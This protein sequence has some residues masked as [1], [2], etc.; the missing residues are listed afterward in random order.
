[1]AL[2]TPEQRTLG[3]QNADA[4]LGATRRDFLKAAAVVPA[5]GAFYFAYTGVEK[6]VKAAIIG[7]G[8]EGCQAMIRDHNRAAI[9]YIGFCD[10]RPSQQVRARKEFEAHKDYSKDDVA[11]LKQYDD[12]DKMLA[13]PDVEMVVIALPLWLH[14]PVAIKA[15]QAGKHVFCEKL[16]AHSVG[17]CKA[18]VATAHDRNRLLAI[19]HQRHYSTLYNNANYLVQNGHLGEIRHIRALWHRNQ[20]CP[21][22]AQGRQGELEVRRQGRPRVRP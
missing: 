21:V 20:A 3:R 12:V 10:S 13:D 1:M 18:M 15:M 14:A 17:Q 22:L 8:N 9:D 19:G 7:T 6:P 5:A 2:L 11:K 4:A 16:M